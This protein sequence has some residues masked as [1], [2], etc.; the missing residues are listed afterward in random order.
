MNWKTINRYIAAGIFLLTLGLYSSTAQPTVAYWDCAEYAAT[1]PAL[2]VPHPPGAPLFTLAGRIADMVPFLSN[3]AFRYNLLSSL[4]SALTIMFLYLIGVRVLSRWKGFPSDPTNGMVVFGSAA[5][6][7]LSYA[8]SDTFWFD[9][10]E[11]SLFASSILFVSLVLWLT[12][13][14]FEKSGKG[15]SHEHLL[16]IAYLLGLSI[17]VHQLCLLPFFTIGILIYFR[18]YEFAWKRFLKFTLAMILGF[19]VIYPGIVKWVVVG[20][21]GKFSLGPIDMNNSSL[22]K[23][24]TFAIIAAAAYSAYKAE[25]ARRWALSMTLMAGLFVLLGYSTYALVYIRANSHPAINENAPGSMHNLAGYLD[26]E[27]YGK[28][29]LFWP[30]RWSPDPTAQRNYA[31]YSSDWD[32]FLSYQLSHMFLRYVGFNFVGRS[33]DIKDAPV[34]IFKSSMRWTGGEKGFPTRYFAI[35]LIIALIGLWYHFRR[36]W[37]FAL[38]FLI[39]FAVMGLALV[40]Y[41]NMADP[42]PRERDYFFVG[43]FFTI[44]LWIGIGASGMIDYAADAVRNKKLKAAGIGIIALAIFAAVPFN[45]FR[46]NLF[47]HDRHDDYAPFDVSY[48]ILQ[49]CKPNAILFT[50]GDNDTFPLWYLQEALGVRTDVRIVCLSLANT[51]WYPLQLK[52]ETPHNAM[53]VPISLPDTEI[54]EIAA[55]GGVQ[56]AQRSMRLDVPKQVYKR[57]DIADTSVTGKGCIRYTVNPTLGQGDFRALRV[58][59]V[60]VN[61]IVQTNRWQRPICFAATVA[62][63]D[64]VGL[65]GFLVREGLVYELTPVFHSGYY[66]ANVDAPITCKCLFNGSNAVRTG[67]HFGF[68][69]EGLDKRGVYYDDNTRGLISVIRDSFM[70]LASHYQENG[71]NRRCVA[72]LDT[73]EERIP[74]KAVPLDYSSMSDISR[75]YFAAG[76]TLSFKKYASLCEKEA[77]AAIADNPFDEQRGTNP[78]AVLLG[79]YEMEGRYRESIALLRQAKEMY[80]NARGIDERIAWLE[81][82][83]KRKD[84]PHSGKMK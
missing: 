10:V 68:I 1:A 37:K 82:I 17:G 19:L 62:P 72:T 32:Y 55:A 81:E 77:L 69:Y 59:D 52:H 78:Y 42:Q 30:R 33:G 44:A 41:F 31:T 64:M 46:Q 60:I 48:D 49:S 66:Y 45:M 13:V 7:A 25:R 35:P 12:L 65:Q 11:S 14:W 6:G 23:V 2:E 24:I 34:A 36:D 22:V 56:W 20:L 5:I 21:S 80:P 70:L 39:L 26:R 38:A 74:V 50:G 84:V 18:Y 47:S 3:P 4:A 63:S 76:D 27:Q 40:V 29:P 43:A 9:A 8:V 51:D 75:L 71:E 53:R 28:Q 16:L 57:F 58:Q 54:R 73:M 15:G 67:P 83:M 79:L 61:D